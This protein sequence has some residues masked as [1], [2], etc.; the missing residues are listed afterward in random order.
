MKR[1]A[2][3]LLVIALAAAA[4][5]EPTVAGWPQTAAE[6]ARRWIPPKDV[7]V[8]YHF[9]FDDTEQLPKHMYVPPP[10]DIDVTYRDLDTGRLLTE[11]GV[12]ADWAVGFHN[13]KF[14]RAHLEA[15]AHGGGYAWC[16]LEVSESDGSGWAV[17][18]SGRRRCRVKRR[19]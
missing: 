9:E 8:W 11:R 14:E 16:I 12:D 10:R 3:A 2:R 7:D 5:I 6:A 1:A 17:S 4:S 19:I 18:D 15:V 13:P